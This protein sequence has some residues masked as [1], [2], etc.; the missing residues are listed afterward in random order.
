[1]KI[2]IFILNCI[3][4][5]IIARNI[6]GGGDHDLI[7]SKILKLSSM[8]EEKSVEELRSYCLKL[9]EYERRGQFLVGGLHDYIETMDRAACK[10]YI[11][12]GAMKN[13]ELLD[14]PTFSKVVQDKSDIAFLT[15]EEKEKPIG[16]GDLPNLSFKVS[17]LSYLL[18]SMSEEE[19]Q[20]FVIRVENWQ[21]KNGIAVLDHQYAYYMKK[22]ESIS[23]IIGEAVKNKQLLEY[24]FFVETI[25]NPIDEFHRR[26]NPS[27]PSTESLMQ[28]IN[29]LE[30][31]ELE[32][33][34]LTCELYTRERENIKNV[35]GGIHD[36]LRSMSDREILD[37][38]NSV[39]MK[40][41]QLDGYYNISKLADQYGLKN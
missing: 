7:A 6:I 30:R 27:G 41:P 23:Y 12:K 16:G 32:R 34:A 3:I 18:V 5:I 4:S 13:I 10:Q 28:F 29:V 40:Y 38:I 14:L 17:K 37:Y 15:E 33:F 36:R 26:Y 20:K 11:L 21:R 19:L 35:Y 9:E 8:L 25:A 22:E 1:M 39:V 31:K 24:D 2:A